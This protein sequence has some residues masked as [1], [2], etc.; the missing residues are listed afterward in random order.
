LPLIVNGYLEMIALTDDFDW[1]EEDAVVVQRQ[2]A[3]AVYA[4]P[5]G[6]LVVRQQ[7]WPDEDVFIVINRQQVRRVI[8]AMERVL[9]EASE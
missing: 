7:R 6:N 9:K 4:N 2:D 3:L 1:N 8:E 5:D